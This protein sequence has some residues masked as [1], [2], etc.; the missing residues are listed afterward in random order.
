MGFFYEVGRRAGFRGLGVSGGL[1]S[2]VS[3]TAPVISG[4]VEI[5]GSFTL[6]DA[7]GYDTFA[8]YRNGVKV[9]GATEDVDAAGLAA[10]V[11]TAADK[12]PLETWE[13]YV[14]AGNAGTGMQS[15]ALQVAGVLDLASATTRFYLHAALAAPTD[16]AP[17]TDAAWTDTADLLRRSMT[18]QQDVDAMETGTLVEWT[19][20]DVAIDR[21]YISPPVHA[22]TLAGSVKCQIRSREVYVTE[23]TQQRLGVRVVSPDGATVRGTLLAVGFYGTRTE[24]STALTNTSYADGDALT[25]VVAQEGDRLVVELGYAD[26]VGASPRG[27]SRWG[28]TG[29]IDLPEDETTTIDRRPWFEIAVT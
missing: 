28:S 7:G 1:G 9:G 23:N 25:P 4:S 26:V 6:D 10:Y 14:G 21:Q 29:G 27:R 5:G 19:A 18:T 22:G 13:G 12:G 20:G 17:T 11:M 2:A 16:V 24:L 8:L 3:L 15:N